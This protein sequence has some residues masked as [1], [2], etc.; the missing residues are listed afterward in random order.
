MMM[1]GS[2][3]FNMQPTSFTS[4][5]L[6]ILLPS[7]TTQKKVILKIHIACIFIEVGVLGLVVT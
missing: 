1:T 4:Y 7:Y 2:I 5:Q 3:F 6:M